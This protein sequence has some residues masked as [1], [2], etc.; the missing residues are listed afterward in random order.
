MS[1]RILL[2]IN[3]SEVNLDA[4]SVYSK[5]NLNCQKKWKGERLF[6]SIIPR[7]SKSEHAKNYSPRKGVEICLARK[8]YCR[9]KYCCQFVLFRN[10]HT[11]FYI[12][13]YL[14]AN[15]YEECTVQRRK[16]DGSR[17]LFSAIDTYGTNGKEDGRYLRG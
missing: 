3:E 6:N 1:C 2:S 9:S 16:T 13:T 14:F 4:L 11:F 12:R 5:E 8:H 15:E 7:S 10:D 17:K